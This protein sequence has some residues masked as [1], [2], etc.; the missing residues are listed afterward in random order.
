MKLEIAY[1][2]ALS[3]YRKYDKAVRYFETTAL[4][5]SSQITYTANKQFLNGE[6]NYLEWVMLINQA[7]SI[8]SDY[9]DALKNKNFSIA[10][11]NSFK[12]N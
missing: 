6:I 5:N 2:S 4:K 1:Q 3:E 11:L 8:Q 9:I 10:E 12:Q 7:I